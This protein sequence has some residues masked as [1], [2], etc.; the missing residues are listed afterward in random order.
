[1]FL[2]LEPPPE[3]VAFE[4]HVGGDVGQAAVGVDDLVTRRHAATS[5][6]KSPGRPRTVRSICA[7]VP[8]P[9]REN[10]SWGYRR[11]HGELLVP[12]VKVAASASW[13]RK[14]SSW[15]V[16]KNLTDWQTTC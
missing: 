12:G 6:P 15:S 11:V 3:V 14:R 10:P 16:T 9:A 13:L 5:R 7:L 4:E 2:S 1:M 8:C